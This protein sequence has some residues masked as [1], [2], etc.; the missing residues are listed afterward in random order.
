MLKTSFSPLTGPVRAGLLAALLVALFGSFAHAQDSE[1]VEVTTPPS[2]KDVTLPTKPS[3]GSPGGPTGETSSGETSSGLC[4]RPDHWLYAK[5]YEKGEMSSHGGKVWRA[6]EQT[7]G[8]MP[9]MGK[10]PR[11]EEVKGHCSA[12][13]Q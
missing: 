12:T 11:W 8:D 4:E 3:P 6:L 2:I 9:G 7:K 1:P 10:E 5:R 13:T